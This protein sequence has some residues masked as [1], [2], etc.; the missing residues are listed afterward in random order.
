MKTGEGVA[1]Y[2]VLFVARNIPKMICIIYRPTEILLLL[3]FFHP[4]VRDKLLMDK[5]GHS[6]DLPSIN[7]QRG[8][9]HG[10]PPYTAWRKRLGLSPV[11]AFD[12]NDTNG[13]RD[14]TEEV[15]SLLKG[16]YR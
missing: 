13:L 12:K 15:A 9:D 7:I 1:F 11:T 14:H 8:R 6:F 10:I 3:R 2:S 5:R 16:A 4:G